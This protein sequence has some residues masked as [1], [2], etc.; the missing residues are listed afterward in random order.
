LSSGNFEWKTGFHVD[1]A[2]ENTVQTG[3]I[4]MAIRLEDKVQRT[5]F[6]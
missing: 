1:R 3:I 4:E 2:I 6:F 5:I